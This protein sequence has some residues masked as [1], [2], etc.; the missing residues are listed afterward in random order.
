MRRGQKNA[1]SKRVG[2]HGH[3]GTEGKEG[4]LVNCSG[5]SGNHHP[6]FVGAKKGKG[7]EVNPKEKDN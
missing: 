2:T 6:R 5:V 7:G 1:T 3:H 4:S